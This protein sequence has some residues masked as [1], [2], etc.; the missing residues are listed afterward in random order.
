MS[1]EQLVGPIISSKYKG[2]RNE[3]DLVLYEVLPEALSLLEDS[4]TVSIAS[5]NLQCDSLQL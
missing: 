5:K 2:I 4:T 1:V 3:R